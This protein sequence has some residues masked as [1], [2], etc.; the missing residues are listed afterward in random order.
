M[1]QRRVQFVLCYGSDGSPGRLDEGQYPMVRLG[2]EML[3]PVCVPDDAG[4]PSFRVGG[5]EPLPVLGYG[6][7]SALGRILRERVRPILEPVGSERPVQSISVVFTAVNGALLKAMALEGRGVAWLP[8]TMVVEDLRSGR[9]RD[10][11]AGKYRVPIEIRLYR[12]HS[13]LTTAAES[14]WAVVQPR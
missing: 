9:L 1:L 12:Q 10:A 7:G 5:S 4:A 8:E 11:G 14:L 2:Q 6:E 3:V 13:E